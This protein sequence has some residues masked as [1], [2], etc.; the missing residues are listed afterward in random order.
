MTAFKM[1]RNCPPG[2]LLKTGGAKPAKQP[3]NRDKRP[4]MSDDHCAQIRK[5]PCAACHSVPSGTIHHLKSGTGER[6]MGLRATDKWGVPLCMTHHD[7][8][9]RAGTRNEVG[10][11]KKWGF[12]PHDLSRALWAST[13]LADTM[14]KIVMA[15]GGKA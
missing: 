9:E 3:G 4:G 2:S 15:T 14:R 13:G 12:D 8:I 5:L 6:G 11:C 7:T 1:H 10:Q